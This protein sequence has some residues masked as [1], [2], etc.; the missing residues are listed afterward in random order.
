MDSIVTVV[1]AKNIRHQLQRGPLGEQGHT[2]GIAQGVLHG[3]QGRT[4]ISEQLQLGGRHSAGGGAAEQLQQPHQASEVGASTHAEML[5]AVNEAQQQVAY[6]DIV[7]L[8]KT[9]LVSEEALV[10]VQQAIRRHN[11]AVKVRAPS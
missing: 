2:A 11:S 3:R 1:D 7:L 8:N 9:D 4:D 10:E 6:A 5:E